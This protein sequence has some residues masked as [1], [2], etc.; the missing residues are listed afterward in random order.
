MN[1][2]PR[3]G[4]TPAAPRQ[5]REL[6][7]VA[8]GPS[9]VA[10]VVI[11]AVVL[12]QLVIA[13]SDMTG[14]LGA[15]ASMWLGVHQVPVSIAGSALGVMPLLPALAMV[16]GT[17]R[18]TAAAVTHTSW[19]V[20][21]WVV[22]SALGGP[23]LIAALCL[24]VI[25]DAASVL[26]QLQTP[27]ASR[28]FASVLTVHLLG[29]A[30]GVGS[31]LGRRLIRP[32][33]PAWL[34]D[35][36]R[37]AAVGVLALTALSAAV[38]A[39]SLVVHWSTMHDLYSITDSLFGQ[40]SLTVLSLLYLPNVVVGAAAVAV[41]SSAHVGLATFSAFTVLGG[42]VPALPV[43]AAAPTPPLGPVWVALLI[44]GAVS[45]VALGQQCARRA[46]PPVQALAKVLVAAALGAAAMALLG[47]AGGGPL[48]NFGDV[49]V[50]QA[51]FGPAVFVW[52]AGIGAL[53]VAMSGGFAPRVRKP[54]PAPPAEDLD[55]D[56][57]P[58]DTIVL[59][60]ESIDAAPV[61]EPPAEPAAEPA[62]PRGQQKPVRE[63]F[64]PA[65]I[66]DFADP[67]DHFVADDDMRSDR[68]GTTH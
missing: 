61:P 36:F 11:A 7:R 46:L 12:L 67:E 59:P 19:F 68:D 20:T 10:L 29:A 66:E 30:L 40:L 44:V 28:A 58:P 15:I 32:P 62:E 3:A 51:T 64:G 18:T 22:A 60:P 65:D 43:L 8:F 16:Y 37:A 4:S 41:G 56:L 55:D 47:Y 48:G 21:R 49:K 24:A 6:L 27:D 33:L 54:R 35:A 34:P 1:T 38:V 13:N 45:G 53:T 63:A 26:T 23:L 25:H 2:A 39:G 17:A 31:R 52:F 42:D 9:L 50:D 57:E 14:A 5:A